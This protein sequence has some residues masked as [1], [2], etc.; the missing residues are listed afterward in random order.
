M[1]VT[2]A[3]IFATLPLRFFVYLCLSLSIIFLSGF[4]E[5]TKII[6]SSNEAL[7]FKRHNK[8]P[9]KLSVQKYKQL[10]DSNAV[11][12]DDDVKRLHINRLES[13]PLI[14]VTRMDWGRIREEL[15]MG[16][17][18]KLCFMKNDVVYAVKVEESSE[19]MIKVTLQK[20][21]STSMPKKYPMV[22][23]N[24]LALHHEIK[25]FLFEIDQ[26]SDRDSS[27]RLR[28]KPVNIG[29]QDWKLF[30]DSMQD[31]DYMA[32]IF[33]FDN[34][35]YSAKVKSDYQQLDEEIPGLKKQY[36]IT[37]IILLVVGL[38]LMSKLYRSVNGIKLLAN[39]MVSVMDLI[40]IIILVVLGFMGMDYLLAE[41][42]GTTSIL[43]QE[44]LLGVFCY[45]PILLIM[46]IVV[47]WKSARGILIN[48]HGILNSD[49]I[50]QTFMSWD[51]LSRM[52]L[53]DDVE[54]S[55][56]RR[57]YKV[58]FLHT[59]DENAITISGNIGLKV[60]RK[61]KTLL[62]KHVPGNKKH[63]MEIHLSSL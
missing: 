16:R 22:G 19:L 57:S 8:P 42:Y 47:S 38:L 4:L 60:K 54:F 11:Q 15:F 43:G 49:L 21:G 17:H 7:F 27:F 28:N 35:L 20:V 24:D 9:K 1:R 52:E 3:K 53:M 41:R 34:H 61:I 25:S 37:G 59:I 2:K 51:E 50:F 45:V 56:R 6:H 5:T 40:V 44:G 55:G 62:L 12:A 48:E 39:Q 63:E 33:I 18:E 30:T 31:L 23:I 26:L 32:T 29:L 46:P 10:C 36:M 58:L 13:T 14:P